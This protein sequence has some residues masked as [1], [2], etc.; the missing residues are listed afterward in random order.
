MSIFAT[1]DSPI[2]MDSQFSHVF[3]S[4]SWESSNGF[5]RN[6]NSLPLQQQQQQ[7]QPGKSFHLV[8]LA[9]EKLIASTLPEM[10][11]DGIP[12]GKENEK[13]SSKRPFSVVNLLF[14]FREANCF[15]AKVRE[16]CKG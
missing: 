12:K 5:M 4:E 9:V 16:L 10:K 14:S 15:H 7:L 3:F 6:P 8:E 1:K 2:P 13:E 11:I